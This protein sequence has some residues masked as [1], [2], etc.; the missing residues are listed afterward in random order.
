MKRIPIKD[1]KEI[2]NNRGYDQVIVFGWSK[3][4]N[5][6]SVVTYGKT[7]KDCDQVAQGGNW[8]KSTM[9]NWPDNECCSEPNR[10]KKLKEEIRDLKQ[11]I[12]HMLTLKD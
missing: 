1:A 9:L 11:Y 3:E 4:D 5:I 8:L 7:V 2:S 6:T 12:M 10:V